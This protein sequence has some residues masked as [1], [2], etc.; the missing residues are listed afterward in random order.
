MS[1]EQIAQLTIAILTLIF[2]PSG[3]VAIWSKRVRDKDKS[4]NTKELAKIKS[5][6]A[7]A[8]ATLANEMVVLKS[9]ADDKKRND[10]HIESL[11]DLAAKRGA[12]NEKMIQEMIAIK[13][14]V[15]DNG[16]RLETA[17]SGNRKAIEETSADTIA[18]VNGMSEKVISDLETIKSKLEAMSE[19]LADNRLRAGNFETLIS[20]VE[21]LVKQLNTAVKEKTQPLPDLSKH[22][23]VA[24]FTDKIESEDTHGSDS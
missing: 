11:I 20:E 1:P 8:L 19:T 22:Q 4:T 15:R 14:G 2:A 3:T 16:D 7:T 24:P 18:S 23:T 17:I 13:D 10:S 6:S 21:T 12:N 5:D 9:N